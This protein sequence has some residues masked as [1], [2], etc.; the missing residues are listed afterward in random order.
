M[1]ERDC[2]DIA[3][4]K[5]VQ[6]ALA[7]QTPV[8]AKL[9]LVQGLA[10]SASGAKGFRSILVFDEAAQNHRLPDERFSRSLGTLWS[11]R[12]CPRDLHSLRGLTFIA[13]SMLW[14]DCRA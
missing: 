3:V 7:P 8:Q 9:G 4:S 14:P 11:V 6:D 2:D 1:Q 12:H 5:E 10:P 13:R